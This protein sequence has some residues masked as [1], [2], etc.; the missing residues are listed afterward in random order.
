MKDNTKVVLTIMGLPA[1]TIAIATL[2]SVAAFYYVGPYMLIYATATICIGLVHLMLI[3]R[4]GGYQKLNFDLGGPK[5]SLYVKGLPDD[6][7]SRIESLIESNQLV[8]I[9]CPEHKFL[10]IA[11]TQFVYNRGGFSELS[12]AECVELLGKPLGKRTILLS[13]RSKETL[14]N[15]ISTMLQRGWKLYGEQGTES[16]LIDRVYTQT[17]LYEPSEATMDGKKRCTNNE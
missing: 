7:H 16:N 14:Q 13:Y 8:L 15:S 2:M 4:H 10:R 6:I 17:M 9:K 5:M 11:L 3:K 1:D 12:K